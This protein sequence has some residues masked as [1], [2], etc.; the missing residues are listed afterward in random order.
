MFKIKVAKFLKNDIQSIF[1]K[2]SDHENYKNFPGV[3]ES[4]LLENGKEEKN[5]KGALR[6]INSG[7][8]EFIE[9]ITHFEP[10]FKMAYVI[11]KSWPLPIVHEKGE[12]I[13]K[14]EDGGTLI[15]WTSEGSVSI[16]LIGP[17]IL[18]KIIEK[19]GTDLFEKTLS[20]LEKKLIPQA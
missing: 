15:T 3:S 10:P 1:N 14:V 18:D 17:F 5:G 2:I 11:E 8:I 12:M 7:S 20:S 16:P 13:L 19:R 6:K 4:I 9:R